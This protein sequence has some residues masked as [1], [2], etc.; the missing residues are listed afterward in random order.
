[1]NKLFKRTLTSLESVFSFVDEFAHT[2]Q[3][4]EAAIFPVRFATEEIFT[5]LV[6]Y[7]AGS[8][9]DIELHFRKEGNR[10]ILE[11][12]D[13]SDK[14]FDLSA[15]PEVDVD[16]PLMERKPGGL[17]IHLTKQFVDEVQYSYDRGKSR[18]TLIKYLEKK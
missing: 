12:I 3:L 1:M 2:E 15:Y 7:N 10:L 11:F 14:P 6:K 9:H 4:S 8:A 16:G 13:Y 17:G 5:N 18:T